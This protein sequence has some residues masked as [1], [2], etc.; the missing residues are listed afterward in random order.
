MAYF[1]VIGSL[2]S[3]TSTTIVRKNEVLNNWI[4]FRA[5]CFMR[6]YQLFILINICRASLPSIPLASALGGRS[7]GLRGPGSVFGGRDRG[8]AN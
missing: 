4:L 6:S 1:L 7:G 8:E 5:I 3:I 2:S